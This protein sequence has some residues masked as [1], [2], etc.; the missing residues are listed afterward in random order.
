KM[1]KY[2]EN[3]EIICA[4]EEHIP[5]IK[6]TMKDFYSDEPVFKAQKID[7]EKLDKS[8][9]EYKEGDFTLVAIDKKNKAV[10]SL[11]IN[12]ITKPD[13]ALK[14]KIHADL[15]N[16]NNIDLYSAL[17]F[18]SSIQSDPCLFKMLNVDTMWEIKTLATA[19][20]YRNLGLSTVVAKQSFEAALLNDDISVI[21]MDCTNYFSAK[22]A[23]NL[24]M[25]C[26]V[27]KHFSEYT[28]DNGHPWIK[29]IPDPPNDTVNV[30]IFKKKNYKN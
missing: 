27:K 23:K 15:Y 26:V 2:S 3:I 21:C 13:N 20:Q 29:N 6:S 10:A 18:W 12:S 8:F 4:R 16:K 22:I 14:Q 24:G 17:R 5:N 9:Y 1:N 19:Q 25:E 7:V 30:F 11:A 28:D